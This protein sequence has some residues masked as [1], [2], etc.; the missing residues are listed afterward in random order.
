MAGDGRGPTGQWIYPHPRDFRRGTF[1]FVSTGDG[2]KP[3][4]ADLVRTIS[5]GLKGTAMPAFH[6]LPEAEREL[7]AAYVTFLSI[8]GAVEFQTLGAILSEG[9][10]E[11]GVDGDPAGFARERLRVIL[12]QWERAAAAPS[13][14]GPMPEPGE[15]EKQAPEYVESVRRGYGLFVGEIG[16]VKCHED[17]GRKATYRYDVWGTVVRPAELT[18][19]AYKGGSK[20]ED[21]FRRI[22]GGISPSGMPAHPSLTDA[23][24]WDLVR[25]VRA[26]PYPRELPPDVRGKVYSN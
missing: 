15:S 2:G 1:K 11:T 3:R 24:V 25:F 13:G 12:G 10:A 6:L 26:L 9:E 8:R 14:P 17:F 16:C 21:Q 18:T 7:M 4:P 19:P 20:P 5:D 23:Q 22:R